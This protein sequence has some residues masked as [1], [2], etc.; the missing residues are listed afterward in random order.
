MFT[1][2]IHVVGG[3][4]KASAIRER[5][6]CFPEVL[7]VLATS[8]HDTLVVVFVGHPREAEWRACMSAAGF[9]LSPRRSAARAPG[10]ARRI[11]APER[12]AA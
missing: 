9:E 12:R 3:R 8:R 1:H 2:E 5:L 6:F 10:A 4:E 7:D 11:S